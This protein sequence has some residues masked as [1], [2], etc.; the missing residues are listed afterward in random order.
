MKKRR[1]DD[2][3]TQILAL[4]EAT[5]GIHGATL[6]RQLGLQRRDKAFLRDCL[7]GLVLSGDLVYLKGGRY[8]PAA[9][10]TVEGRL[11]VSRKGGGLVVT[12][13]GRQIE[14]SRHN[15]AGALDGDR[16]AV[17]LDRPRQGRGRRRRQPEGPMTGRVQRVVEPGK[18]RVIGFIERNRG[19]TVLVPS[20]GRMRGRFVVRNGDRAQ[21]GHGVGGFV[22][23]REA[24]RPVFHVE[25]DVDFGPADRREAIAA[26]VLAEEGVD[27]AFPDGLVPAR[28]H[29]PGPA[30]LADRRDLRGLVSFTID[31]DEAHDFDDAL[32]IEPLDDGRWRLFVH[33]ADVTHYVR[34][35]TAVD[36]EARKRGTSIYFP[37]GC[38]PMLPPEL[39]SDLCSLLAGRDRLCLTCEMLVGTDGAIV[40]SGVHK[41]VITSRARLT[42]GGVQRALDRQAGLDGDLLDPL[43]HLSRLTEVRKL[44]RRERG[45]LDL[46]L[47]EAIPVVDDQGRLT[48]L[49]RQQPL[50][51]Y[52]IVEE[53][54][55]A[56][57]ECVARLAKTHRLPILYRHH[58]PPS[59]EKVDELLPL[60]DTF[61]VETSDLKLAKPQ[62]W[63]RLLTRV[64][65]HEGGDA[66][67]PFIIRSQM[68]ATYAP[69]PSGHF[70]LALALYCHFTS[71]IRRYPDL[72]THR[73]V[74]THLAGGDTTA[75]TGRALEGLA[76][77]CSTTEQRAERIDREVLRRMIL[78]FVAQYRGCRFNA[79]VTAVHPFGFFVEVQD[80]FFEGMVPVSALVD[81]YYVCHEGR[82]VM[83]GRSTKRR[84][85]LGDRLSVVLTRVDPYS[86]QVDF[87][88][89]DLYDSMQP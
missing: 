62:G 77:H 10:A 48:D 17:V 73:L 79:V 1:P 19:E 3:R 59:D 11:T 60:L 20:D 12:D 8:K 78:P 22:V 83:T 44:R 35:D 70:G 54:M 25:L 4:V 30:D 23:D 37:G 56:A 74:K 85:A 88:P 67:L 16:V 51:S 45:G 13:D 84:F 68:R 46:F 33:I 15:L 89:A 24:G 71:P 7:K 69:R 5:P 32:S 64:A 61:G 9:G 42:Y 50:F 53:C 58:P 26:M 63:Q 55:L 29:E 75:A 76:E 38:V 6:G 43:V 18:R 28:L 49:R 81:D 87:V 52:Q 27:P 31:G 86:R 41:S 36:G 82:G 40:R 57:N 66:L 2:L 39:S 21:A 80:P 34:P 14:I 47:P 65:D 72:W